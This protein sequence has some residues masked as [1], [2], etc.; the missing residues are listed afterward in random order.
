MTICMQDS[1]IATYLVQLVYTSLP[2]NIA[3]YSIVDAICTYQHW[4]I[5]SYIA[6][7]QPGGGGSLYPVVIL[8]TYYVENEQCQPIDT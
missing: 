2:Y 7:G 4:I 6:L 3:I 5:S 1:Y 8:S